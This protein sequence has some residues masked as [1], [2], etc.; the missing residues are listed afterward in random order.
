MQNL[1]QQ[2]KFFTICDRKI[3]S[4]WR[5]FTKSITSAM[6]WT[7]KE[8]TLTEWLKSN[9]KLNSNN[10]LSIWSGIGAQVNLWYDETL[11]LNLSCWNSA[12]FYVASCFRL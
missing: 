11:K 7:M 10:F 8:K 9:P 5:K 3:T 4:P 6:Q 1:Q 12:K 2:Q